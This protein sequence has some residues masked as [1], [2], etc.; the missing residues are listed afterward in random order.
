MVMIDVFLAYSHKRQKDAETLARELESLGVS[1]WV[2]SRDIRVGEPIEHEIFGAIR[3][4]RL[5]AFLADPHSVAS[6]SGWVQ[7]EYMAALEQSW[8]DKDKILVPVLIGD[9]E[10]PA[11]LKHARALKVTDRKRGWTAAAKEIAKLLRGELTSKHNKAAA[12]E[13][14][15]RLNLI[16]REANALR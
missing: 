2:A 6:P 4:A 5:V 8:L 3:K 16:E 13:Q 7:R 15:E 10:P 12:K 11:F 9:A 1:A 14:V